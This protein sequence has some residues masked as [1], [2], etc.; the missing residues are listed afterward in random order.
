MVPT[1]TEVTERH[2]V[3]M[4][5]RVISREF[6]FKLTVTVLEIH[7]SSRHYGMEVNEEELKTI[8]KLPQ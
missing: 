3:F 5:H 7:Y 4:L 1:H 6:L 8:C 2:S